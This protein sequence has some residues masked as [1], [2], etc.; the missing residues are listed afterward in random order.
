V[1][2]YPFA[3]L[4]VERRVGHEQSSGGQHGRADR[5]EGTGGPSSARLAARREEGGN[6]E[7][8]SGWCV[9]SGNEPRAVQPA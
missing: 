2:R 6:F 1:A 7:A 4:S 5:Q 3:A 9:A 8:A